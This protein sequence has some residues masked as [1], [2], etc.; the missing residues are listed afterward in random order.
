M[1]DQPMRKTQARTAERERQR[2]KQRQKENLMRLIPIGALVLFVITAVVYVFSTQ[3]NA[4]T[5][6]V[7]GPRLQVDHEKLEL[8]KQIFDRPIRA[9]FNVKNVG[10]GT[11]KLDVPKIVN[12]LEG[13]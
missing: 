6:G 7:N 12:A 2:A 5:T 4:N 13:C 3:S 10:D 8:G 11:L 1:S 9:A